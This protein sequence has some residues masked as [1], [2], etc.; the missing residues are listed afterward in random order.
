M[1]KS[2]PEPLSTGS[3]PQ[4]PFAW[5]PDGRSVVF[6]QGDADN[7]LWTLRFDENGALTPGGPK[8]LI[9]RPEWQC[10]AQYSPDGKWL[11]FASAETGTAQLFVRS[12]NDAEATVQVSKGTRVGQGTFSPVERRIF[13][14]AW[15]RQFFR[16]FTFASGRD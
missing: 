15:E 11:L 10:C 12:V 6:Q 3:I 9:D 14:S 1:P 7:D 4:F 8:K 2:A 16:C 5:S 13:Y